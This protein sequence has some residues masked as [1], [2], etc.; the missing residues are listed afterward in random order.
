MPISIIIIL[1]YQHQI[2]ILR[3]LCVLLRFG[4][5][6]QFVCENYVSWMNWAQ[7]NSTKTIWYL[8][9]FIFV[10]V[11]YYCTV[12][13]HHVCF[14][15]LYYHMYLILPLAPISKFLRISSP[16][17]KMLSATPGF[18][19]KNYKRKQKSII[20]FIVWSF[21]FISRW[22]QGDRRSGVFCL[23][24]GKSGD[25]VCCSFWGYFRLSPICSV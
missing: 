8:Y 20:S 11:D 22:K 18:T 21:Y 17:Y 7:M 2:E 6:Q 14:C 1:C 3:F 12:H 10:V 5:L 15:L 9:L 24:F 4:Y 25:R 19:K 13:S 16:E 23:Y